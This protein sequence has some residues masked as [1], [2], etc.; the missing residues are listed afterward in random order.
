MKKYLEVV[1]LSFSMTRGGPHSSHSN[2]FTSSSRLL[3]KFTGINPPCSPPSAMS[4][5]PFHSTL[6]P[7]RLTPSSLRSTRRI[8]KNTL[9]FFIKKKKRRKRIIFLS[10]PHPDFFSFKSLANFPCQMKILLFLNY[11]L[12]KEIGL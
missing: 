10:S 12:Q 9:A 5:T 6:L 8:I 4:T 7:G 1:H 3:H 11:N 2:S